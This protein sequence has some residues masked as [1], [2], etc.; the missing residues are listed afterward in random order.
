MKTALS[1]FFLLMVLASCHKKE[2]APDCGCEGPSYQTLTNVLGRYV[3]DGIITL[4]PGSPTNPLASSY[5]LSCN[6]RFVDGKVTVG[7]TVI[8]S[9]YSRYSCYRGPVLET[10]I[11]IPTMLDLTAIRKK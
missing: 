4:T 3:K 9:G 1:F 8:F 2:A 6:P 7:D 10:L 5:A 11:A